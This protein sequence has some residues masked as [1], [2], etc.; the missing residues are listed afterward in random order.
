MV[1]LVLVLGRLPRLKGNSVRIRGCPAA[2]SENE[3]H[4]EH[5]PS[6]WEAVRPRNPGQPG[7]LAEPEDLPASDAGRNPS[8]VRPGS[9]AGGGG[10]TG[11]QVDDRAP[12]GADP[13]RGAFT[14][15]GG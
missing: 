8:P 12:A 5:W 4:H 11:A 1:A 9:F 3:P 15:R 14:A 7:A 13:P 2:V 6:G 10:P